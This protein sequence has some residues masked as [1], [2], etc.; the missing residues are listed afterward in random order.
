MANEL[1]NEEGNS[2]LNIARASIS[3]KFNINKKDKNNKYKDQL[4]N[5]H[6]YEKRGVFVTLH[7]NK[8]LRGCIGTIEPVQSI[9]D[10]IKDNAINAAFK[11][12]RFPPLR[13]DEL[14]DTDIE[15]S[16]LTK[17]VTLEYTDYKDLLSKLK[18]SI[19]GVILKKDYT[20]ATFLPQVWEQLPDT[21]D[22]LSQLCK[23]A[24]LAPGEWKKEN[25][26][27]MVYQVQ[28]FNEK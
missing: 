18:P 4:K 9:I 6:L 10:G 28:C 14:V 5:K 27:I 16:I 20:R 1:T 22:F 2:L 15:I 19:H 21:K 12:P 25:I 13:F 17:P 26:E 23:K 11:D 3:H 24:D 7:K 8:Q